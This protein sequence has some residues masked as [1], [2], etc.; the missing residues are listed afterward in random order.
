MNRCWRY[1]ILCS[2]CHFGFGCVCVCV[3]VCVIKE[4]ICIKSNISR[5][6]YKKQQHNFLVIE[7]FHL[8][9]NIIHNDDTLISNDTNNS[10]IETNAYPN[11]AIIVDKIAVIDK[12]NC[13]N[14]T[15]LNSIASHCF[16]SIVDVMTM[17]GNRNKLYI[18]SF[19][20]QR[21]IFVL[22]CWLYWVDKFI[23]TMY[24]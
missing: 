20:V 6:E 7:S 11:I 13:F 15:C 5:G 3:C 16:I 9:I 19:H 14:A 18:R 23:H 21:Y 22:A 2:F 17:N 10:G 8:Y 12:I 24:K 4:F 1:V